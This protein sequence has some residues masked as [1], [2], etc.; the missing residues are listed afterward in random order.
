[1]SPSNYPNQCWNIVNWTLRNKL[2]W[3]FNGNSK[4]CILKNAL[5]NVVCEM[6]SILSRP[7]CV[8]T[9]FLFTCYMETHDLK[10]NIPWPRASLKFMRQH[11]CMIRE[12]NHHVRAIPTTNTW[13]QP[14]RGVDNVYMDSR[15]LHAANMS[16]HM[17]QRTQALLQNNKKTMYFQL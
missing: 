1:M 2:Q 13:I 8:N 6:A 10:Q 15:S 14:P 16:T 4:I 7:Q 3:Y 12:L 9:K 11:I 5:E 17:G